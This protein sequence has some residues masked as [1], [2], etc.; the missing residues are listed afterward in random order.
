MPAGFERCVKQGGRV[1]TIKPKPGRY[2]HVCYL[3]GKSYRGEVKHTKEELDNYLIKIKG[4]EE[5]KDKSYKKKAQESFTESLVFSFKEGTINE[6]KRTVRVCALAPCISRNNRYYSPE[7][8]ERASGTLQGKQSFADHDQRDTK[9][10]IGRIIS[11]EYKGGRLYADIKISKAKGIASQTWEKIKDGTVDAVS[12]AADGQTKRVMMGNKV[13][14][15]VRELDIKSVDFVTAG[16]I[17]DAKVMRVF[18]SVNDI[19]K[20]SEV[21]QNMI[22]NVEQMREEYPDLVTEVEEATKKQMQDEITKAN[23]RAEDAEHKLIAKELEDYK[24]TEISKLETTDEVK[25]ILRKKVN[26]KSKDEI[27]ANL[28]TEFDYIKS[29]EKASKPK[30]KEAKIE[31]VPEAGAH[32]EKKNDTMTSTSIREDEKIPEALK[33]RCVE[34][35]WQEGSDKVKEFLKGHGIEL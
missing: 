24:E 22:E 6:E 27:S 29:I 33:G 4:G 5:V 7:V 28:R 25:N 30:K 2:L 26:G 12:I 20:I 3:G 8:V 13:V 16:G 14:D 19:P 15:E 10:L 17:K 11:E 18:E 31:G 21:K 32:T 23:K 9:N 35:L 1:R 34:I